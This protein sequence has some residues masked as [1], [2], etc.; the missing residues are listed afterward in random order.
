MTPEE[1]A[2]WIRD[3]EDDRLRAWVDT[4]KEDLNAADPGSEWAEACLCALVMLCM[5]FNRRFPPTLH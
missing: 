4:A 2:Q 3:L 1:S 5:E